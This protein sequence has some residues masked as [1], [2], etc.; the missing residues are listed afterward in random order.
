MLGETSL[1]CVLAGQSQRTRPVLA[2]RQPAVLPHRGN[3][4]DEVSA[5]SVGADHAGRVHEHRLIAESLVDLG[6]PSETVDEPKLRDPPQRLIPRR[7]PVLPENDG[8][9]GRPVSR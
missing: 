7:P 1:M 6:A 9:A 4:L 8:L 3:V 2:L 5:G